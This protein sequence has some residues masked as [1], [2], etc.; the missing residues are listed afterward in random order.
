MK[1]Y[2]LKFANLERD[3]PIVSL[4]PVIKVAS[5]NFLGDS[6]LVQAS[7]LEIIRVLKDVKFDCLVGP[8]V[9]VVPILQELTRLLKQPRYVVFRKN[10]TG[11]MVNPRKLNFF[12]GGLVLDGRDVDYLK[13][14]RVVVVDDVVTTGHTLVYINKFL[15]EID[16]EVVL[17]IAIFKQDD[18]KD[19]NVSNF[20]HIAKL[21]VFKK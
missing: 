19:I 1:F 16:T 5:V 11:Y 13:G 12:H 10:I 2:K 14:K 9:K 7:A 18:G 17:N 21:P 15:S 3:L 8:E 4:S 6:E 20:K